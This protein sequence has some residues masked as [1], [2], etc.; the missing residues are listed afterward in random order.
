MDTLRQLQA[1][2]ARLQAENTELRQECLRNRRQELIAHLLKGEFLSAEQI[3]SDLRSVGVALTKESFVELYVNVL[4]APPPPVK[5]ENNTYCAPQNF[6]AIFEDGLENLI[7][8]AYSQYFCAAARWGTGVVAILQ[9]DHSPMDIPQ[10]GSFIEDLNRRA[11][12]LTDSLSA[13]HHIN[14]FVAI[15][16]PHQGAGGIPEAHQEVQKIDSY[17]S[18]MGIEVPLLCYHDFEMAEQDKLDEFNSLMLEQTY[19][20][21]IELGHFDQAHDTMKSLIDLE[22]RKNIPSLDSLNTALASKLGLLLV[23]LRK[24]NTKENTAVYNE[25]QEL[26]RRLIQQ[27]LTVEQLKNGVDDVFS[28]IADFMA[29]QSP[30]WL[31]L[32]LQYVDANFSCTELNVAAISSAFG[33]NSS[34]MSREVKRCTGST[35]LDLLQKKRLGSAINLIHSGSGMAV[36]ARESGFGDVKAL[37]R[38]MKRYGTA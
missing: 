36:A 28:Q 19:L 13:L 35:L 24:F 37:R 27:S 14:T 15:S 29:Q 9:M 5:L 3:V 20:T 7:R 17:R 31:P 21:S 30:K 1:E 34:Y 2:V 12:Q 38:A 33:L 6:R 22:F 11:L 23:A 18:I 10:D 16:R 8:A 4:I 26:Q 25:V 32:L